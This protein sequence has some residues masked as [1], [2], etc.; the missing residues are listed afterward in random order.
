MRQA[1]DYWQ[2]QPDSYNKTLQSSRFYSPAHRYH[3]ASAIR[4]RTTTSDSCNELSTPYDRTGASHRAVRDSDC[5]SSTVQAT[6]AT[7]ASKLA[8]THQGRPIRYAGLSTSQYHG[9]TATA[10]RP[11]QRSRHRHTTSDITPRSNILGAKFATLHGPRRPTQRK[12]TS[13]ANASQ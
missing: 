4:K 1:Y 5:P 3:Q 7:K 11:P 8:N 9:V 12:S 2:D 10:V 13:V 6:D